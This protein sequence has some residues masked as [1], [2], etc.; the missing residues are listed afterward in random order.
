MA[1]TPTTPPAPAP[2]P[3]P[4]WTGGRLR[5]T[6]DNVLAQIAA[7]GLTAAQKALLAEEVGRIPPEFNLVQVDW[8]RLEFK[9]GGSGTFTVSEL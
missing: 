6:R 2:K 3:A 7:S 5:D 9:S 1:N 8:H 4:P